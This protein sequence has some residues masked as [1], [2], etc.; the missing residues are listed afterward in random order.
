MTAVE[1]C[2][3]LT[4]AVAV[5]PILFRVLGMIRIAISDHPILNEEANSRTK[6]FELILE[7]L[8][9]YMAAIS[10]NCLVHYYFSLALYQL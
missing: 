9:H 7:I 8:S 2:Y 1:N 3:R 6:I 10:S 5:E 4:K